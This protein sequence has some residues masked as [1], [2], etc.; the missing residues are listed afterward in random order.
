MA[1]VFVYPQIER[2]RAHQVEIADLPALV[3]LDT[4]LGRNPAFTSTSPDAVAGRG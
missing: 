3:R 4:E 1:D 2:L